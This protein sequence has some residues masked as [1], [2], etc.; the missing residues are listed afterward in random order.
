[1]LEKGDTA[2]AR[3]LTV[4]ANAALIK[5]AALS[6]AH[7]KASAPARPPQ[8]ASAAAGAS[9]EPAAATVVIQPGQDT[10][11]AEDPR[12][13]PASG[14]L[15]AEIAPCTNNWQKRR[16]S[17]AD[18]QWDLRAHG[19]E[20][21]PAA[22]GGSAKPHMAPTSTAR[23][24]APPD[25]QGANAD[26]EAPPLV[27][28]EGRPH[29]PEEKRGPSRSEPLVKLL[30]DEADE[31]QEGQTEARVNLAFASLV[32]RADAALEEWVGAAR[33]RREG[34]LLVSFE[35]GA[36]IKRD[37]RKRLLDA[38][39]RQ[40]GFYGAV[41]DECVGALLWT[42]ERVEKC[43]DLRVHKHGK[44]LCQAWSVV[45][46]EGAYNP[47]AKGGNLSIA[48][49]GVFFRYQ[50]SRVGGAWP[51]GFRDGV[52]SL[53]LQHR[54]RVLAGI[55]DG[56]AGDLSELLR[57]CGAAGTGALGLA[58]WCG[59]SQVRVTHPHYIVILG[60]AQVR[61]CPASEQPE[62]P[63]WANLALQ[64][65]QQ[66][67]LLH[68]LQHRQLDWAARP[69]WV[70]LTDAERKEQGTYIW[71]HLHRVIFKAQSANRLT[72]HCHTL[73]VF[74]E[75]K[76]R[77]P[78]KGAEGRKKDRKREARR[79]KRWGQEA[80]TEPEAAASAAAGAHGAQEELEDDGRD[81]VD[82]CSPAPPQDE[83][84][85]P[86]RGE[87][88]EKKEEK[89][90]KENKK[91]KKK[92][93]SRS[94]TPK[95]TE[96]P[97]QRG[98]SRSRRREREQRRTDRKRKVPSQQRGR[99]RS[100]RRGQ[101]QRSRDGKRTVPSQQRG[102]SRSGRSGRVEGGDRQGARLL[103]RQPP[104]PPPA[105]LRPR[106]P[107]QPGPAQLLPRQPPQPPAAQLRPRKPPPPEDPAPAF[108]AFSDRR[109]KPEGSGD[110]H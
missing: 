24:P 96:P 107:L 20:S 83:K 41:A 94:R 55:F 50:T 69:T 59:E 27:R 25:H 92:S 100:R 57:G 104:H 22:A 17:A 81:A 10:S 85:N 45:L 49:G 62:L 58:F 108:V 53:V 23:T 12:P 29:F 93:E 4:A 97:Q 98:R 74:I 40:S 36:D 43:E 102:R 68:R 35:P 70:R 75:G 71:P 32:L 106:Q 54:V 15:G 9:V 42:P 26:G 76:N 80:E 18:K 8:A 38:L 11:R 95:R 16:L 34:V 19:R 56:D 64:P 39:I 30:Y 52:R 61:E 14:S 7:S 99:S 105:R 86:D 37:Q 101:E 77:K 44:F 89:K 109:R 73:F 51:Q 66:R 88:K 47:K 60:P 46:A 6:A 13:Q 5:A 91:K 65:P 72:E 1:M 33:E 110:S 87:R 79:G 84:R 82:A 63:S 103:P 78:G 31:V 67:G 48:V 28:G 21:S 90:E 2:Q 3:T